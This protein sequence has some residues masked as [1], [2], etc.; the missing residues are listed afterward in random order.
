MKV[1]WLR[2]LV[3]LFLLGGAALTGARA[4]VR[5]F[6]VPPQICHL[7]KS[8][9]PDPL[10]WGRIASPDVS[11]LLNEDGDQRGD[12]WPSFDINPGTHEA[13]CTWSYNDGSTYRIA[14][15][16][17]ADGLWVPITFLTTPSTSEQDPQIA[18]NSAGGTR[19]V[20][21]AGDTDPTVYMIERQTDASPWSAPR[22]VSHGNRPS[23]YPTA[24]VAYGKVH[25]GYE[26]TAQQGKD[27]IISG[28]D[29]L[30][31]NAPFVAEVIAH[32][33]YTGELDVILET[34]GGKAWVIWVHSGGQI[35]YSVFGGT[36]WATPQFRTYSDPSEIEAIR[37]Q[38]RNEILA[39][40]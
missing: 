14:F 30:N 38:I 12:G 22:Q 8:D 37:H 10:P 20:Y 2:L 6:E 31:E 32:T 16:E 5:A 33:S 40:Q 13:E 11:N 17:T 19:I 27:I 25:V 36:M 39:Q 7:H 4:E 9:T 18:H 23:R 26:A 24:A 34:L 3:L 29:D 35:G 15:S 28:R 21:W 1:P